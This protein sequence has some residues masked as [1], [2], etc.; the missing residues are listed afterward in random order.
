MAGSGLTTV[1]GTFKGWPL[2]EVAALAAAAAGPARRAALENAVASRQTW[3]ADSLTP[4]DAAAF[5]RWRRADLERVAAERGIRPGR[6]GRYARTAIAGLTTD[7]D[8]MERVRRMQLLGPDQAAQHMEI[9][10]RDFDYV[11]AAGWVCPVPPRSPQS[12]RRYSAASGAASALRRVRARKL[13][14]RRWRR[15]RYVTGAT[16]RRRRD[17]RLCPIAGGLCVV[18]GKAPLADLL[19]RG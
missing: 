17:R 7:E 16:D 9:R 8:L 13:R 18:R 5:L 12:A 6:F 19:W 14:Q 10:R 2:Y 4:R 1:V 11:T 15:W 3:L